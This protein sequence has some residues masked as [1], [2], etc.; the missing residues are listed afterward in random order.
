MSFQGHLRPSML[1]QG[2]FQHGRLFRLFSAMPFRFILAYKFDTCY[3]ICC[4]SSMAFFLDQA[5]SKMAA[6][7]SL[8]QLTTF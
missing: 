4:K 7:S 1:F 2:H 3:I 5:T 8:F 6:K